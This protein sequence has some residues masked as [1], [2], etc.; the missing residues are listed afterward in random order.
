M[1]M[2]YSIAALAFL[3]TAANA[4]TPE[5]CWKS[6]GN[7]QNAAT[8]SCEAVSAHNAPYCERFENAHSKECRKCADKA[9]K[10]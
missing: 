5:N 2:I 8:T 6:E 10:V 1:K 3:A 9:S 7:W 4:A